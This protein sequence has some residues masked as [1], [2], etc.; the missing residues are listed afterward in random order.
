MALSS[1]IT[2]T[3]PLPFKRWCK[4]YLK[5]MI[6]K[7]MV[8]LRDIVIIR[9]SWVNKRLSA[10]H[11]NMTIRSRVMSWC[12][13][14]IMSILRLNGIWICCFLFLLWTLSV[15]KRER[16]MHMVGSDKYVSLGVIFF[17]LCSLRRGEGSTVKISEI[18]KVTK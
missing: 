17:T 18:V 2:P 3:K 14:I 1:Q 16:K 9:I 4:D 10:Y 13:L 5:R 11:F 12:Q 7:R 8:S 15:W 6:L